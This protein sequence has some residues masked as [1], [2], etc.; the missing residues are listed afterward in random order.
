[1]KIKALLLGLTLASGTVMSVD[2]AVSGFSKVKADDIK[3]TTVT[4][5]PNNGLV[6]QTIKKKLAS[7]KIEVQ[8][9]YDSRFWQMDTLMLTSGD[10][11]DGLPPVSQSWSQPLVETSELILAL[12]GKDVELMRPGEKTVVGRLQ[13]WNGTTGLLLFKD[14]RQ[15]LFEWIDGFSLRSV[16]GSLLSVEQLM[17]DLKAQFDLATP[18]STLN[19]SYFNRGLNF[20]N[21]YRLVLQPEKSQLALSFGATVNNNSLTSYKKA[22][23]ILAAGDSGENTA[24]S[25][26]PRMIMAKVE[27]SA[28]IGDSIR[29]GELLFTPVPGMFDLPARSSVSVYLDSESE[30]PYKTSYRYSFFGSAHSGNE[31]VKAHPNATIRFMSSKD[32]PAGAVQVFTTSKDAALRMVSSGQLPQT[33]GKNPVELNVGQ[34][35]TVTVERSRFETEQTESGWE[36]KWQFKVTNSLAKPV[37][38]LL[39]DTSYQLLNIIKLSGLKREGAELY[40]EIPAE[41]TKTITFTSLYSK[42]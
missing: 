2:A 24:P 16:S 23:I 13:A 12:L 3:S 8:I 14:G 36:V 9:P 28:G 27:D 11:L 32:L 5:Y 4:V 37:R 7:G 38:L 35:Y 31:V 33:A 21:R 29:S 1:M 15:E 30:I 25:Y 18:I 20:S 40:V 26:Q 6:H 34:A 41:N 17:P 19:L 10:G 42:K 39:E 22:S